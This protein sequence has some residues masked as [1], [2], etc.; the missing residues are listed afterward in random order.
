[1]T[2]KN[3]TSLS[4]HIPSDNFRY[5]GKCS[6]HCLPIQCAPYSFTVFPTDAPILPWFGIQFLKWTS[7]IKMDISAAYFE[8]I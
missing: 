8:T 1:M 4:D 2:L 5:E 3:G 6:I 7:S